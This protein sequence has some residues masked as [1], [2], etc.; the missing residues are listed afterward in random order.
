MP[1]DRSVLVRDLMAETAVLHE[2]IDP[3]DAAELATPTASAGWT[4]ADQVGHLAA[5]DEI[6]MLAA[7][8]LNAFDAL[9]KESLAD[10]DAMV[11]AIV[12]RQPARTPEALRSWLDEARSDMVNA[13]LSVDPA[14]KLAW[15]GPPMSAASSLT[16]RIMETWAHT[17]DIA[18]ALGV[19]HPATSAL[20]QV[21]HLGVRTVGFSF[22][23]YGLKAPD[24]GVRVSLAG[25]NGT[26]VDLGDPSSPN[27][28]SGDLGEFCLVVTRRR[29]V[30]D[31]GLV[32]ATPAART[33]LEVTQAF[34]GPPGPPP[35]RTDQ[36]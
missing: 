27:V 17:Q 29:H 19:A 4:I 30:D 2:L 23:A 31:T 35:Q 16:A 21:A 36:R 34:A 33:W 11:D 8:D 14:T 28:V 10:G 13:L 7:V 6:A 20:S 3:L 26:S 12:A 18:D 9:A 32:A 25:P 24:D 1:V 22:G 5:F 15:F